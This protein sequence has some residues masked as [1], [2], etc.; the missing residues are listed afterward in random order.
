MAQSVEHPTLDL[1]SAQVMISW[2]MDSSP[3]SGSLL[4]LLS[5]QNLLQISLCPSLLILSL[6]LTQK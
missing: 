1:V 4:S 3:T 5:A 2:F 6:S